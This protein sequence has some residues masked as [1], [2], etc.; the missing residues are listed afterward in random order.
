MSE[1]GATPVLTSA[2]CV[3]VRTSATVA[4]TVHREGAHLVVHFLQP[5]GVTR[6]M[7]PCEV[8]AA[9]LRHPGTVSG[10]DAVHVVA[11]PDTADL[12]VTLDGAEGSVLL[13]VPG[14]AVR[15]ALSR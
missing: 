3:L 2:D 13:A 6:W 10:D 12:V 1:T 14:D 5:G 8:V 7:W 11:D 4:T 9:A 15:T